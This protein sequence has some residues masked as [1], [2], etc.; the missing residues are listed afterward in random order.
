[1]ITKPR[2]TKIAVAYKPNDADNVPSRYKLVIDRDN[3][4]GRFTVSEIHNN[5]GTGFVHYFRTEARAFS[6]CAE[7]G[8][9]E[10]VR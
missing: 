9:T 7:L 5:V 8:Y 4:F 3:K 2:S 10:I 6:H 1:V